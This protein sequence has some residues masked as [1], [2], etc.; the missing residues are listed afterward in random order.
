MSYIKR[1]MPG[2]NARSSVLS[3]MRQK[4]EH[5]VEE[6]ISFE[7]DPHLL[8]FDDAWSLVESAI[9]ETVDETEI[10][11]DSVIHPDTGCEVDRKE[12]FRDELIHSGLNLI[13]DFRDQRG[14]LY[15]E[16]TV[17]ITLENDKM[18]IMGHSSAAWAREKWAG[19]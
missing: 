11:C 4:V 8:S 1:I 5:R 6:G 18:S 16:R 14:D 2:G 13:A 10:E 15:L 17:F 3:K 7:K 9:D 12:F 19:I